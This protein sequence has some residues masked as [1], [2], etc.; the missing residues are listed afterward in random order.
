M[1]ILG[2]NR[3]YYDGVVGSMGIDKTIVYERHTEEYE[4]SKK[5]PK[6]FKSKH[7]YS[8]EESKFLDLC[9]YGIDSKKTKK[10]IENDIFF[11]GFCGKIYIGWK[12]YYKIGKGIHE[13]IKCDFIYDIDVAKKYIKDNRWGSDNLNDSINYVMNYDPINIF[14]EFNTPIFV[15][16]NYINRSEFGRYWGG[17]GSDSR[18]I[19]NPVLKEYKFYKVFDT[20]SAFQEIQ[21]FISGVLGADK[22]EI[23]EVEDKYKITQHGFDKWSFRREPSKKKK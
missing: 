21:M 14:R 4:D 9:H 7:Y 8:D 2:K 5:F 19:V 22:K 12:F 23:I 1:L 13:K 17:G 6:E 20:F 18:F 3:D 15:Y 10:Y 11:I 16:D